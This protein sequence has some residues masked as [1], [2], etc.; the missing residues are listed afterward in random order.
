MGEVLVSS[1]YDITLYQ[2]ILNDF[3][4]F[5]ETNVVNMHCLQVEG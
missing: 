3:V 4:L 1:Q 5:V 2:G